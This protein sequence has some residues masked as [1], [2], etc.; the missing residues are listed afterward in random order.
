VLGLVSSKRPELESAGELR[1]RV[2]EAA[3]FVPRERLAISPQCGF[4]STSEGNLLT[5]DDQR[6]KLEL[7][8]RVARDVW[9]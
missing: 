3:R 2:A 9:S 7:V 1:R 8:A 6:K 4:A 5:A